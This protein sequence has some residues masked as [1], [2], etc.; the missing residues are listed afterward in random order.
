MNLAIAIVVGAAL[1]VFVVFCRGL[2]Q[3]DRNRHPFWDK[4]RP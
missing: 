2:N 3:H 4:R 1:L